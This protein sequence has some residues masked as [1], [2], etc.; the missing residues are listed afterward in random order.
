MGGERGKCGDGI[1]AVMAG[2]EKVPSCV[3]TAREALKNSLEGVAL[4]L[5]RDCCL[6]GNEPEGRS[7][8][9]VRTT[10]RVAAYRGGS[11]QRRRG[12]LEPRE[13]WGFKI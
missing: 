10:E 13:A 4:L 8:F 3:P 12:V 5:K 2:G 11:E 9:D 6:P 1:G 7:L